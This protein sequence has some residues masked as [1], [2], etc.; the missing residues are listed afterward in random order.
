MQILDD[1]HPKQ[2]EYCG[3][4]TISV[5]L[6]NETFDF[7]EPFQAFLTLREK[8]GDEVYL[9]ESLSGP[10]RDCHVSMIGLGKLI[11]IHIKQNRIEFFGLKNLIVHVVENCMKSKTLVKIENILQ[12]T[13]AGLWNFLRS[14]E[15]QFAM[16]N[17]QNSAEFNFGFFAYF[18][19]DSAWFI[20]NLPHSIPARADVPDICLTIYSHVLQF[21]VKNQTARMI[22]ATSDF[23]QWPSPA[24]IKNHLQ[25]K[26]LISL[27]DQVVPAVKS[28]EDSVNKSQYLKMVAKALDY[29]K[30]GDIY[31]VQ[32]GHEISIQTAID[33]LLVYHRLRQR[34][35][36]PYL[37]FAPFHAITLIGASPELFV[38]NVQ[39]RVTLRPIAGTIK[40]Q[41]DPAAE[42]IAIAAFLKDKKEIA[43]H[44]M[45][46][47]LA[48][49]DIGRICRPNTLTTDEFMV[50]EKYSHV[51]HMVSNV[52]GEASS[53]IDNYQIIAATF[54]EGTVSGAPKIRALEI[55]EEIE[56]KRRGPYA[57]A[58]GVIDFS[59]FMNLALIIRTIVKTDQVYHIRASA[60]IVADSLPEKEWQETMMKMAA[61]YWALTDKELQL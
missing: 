34:N 42:A 2:S 59:G 56:T 55:I 20:E 53:G 4:H 61:T 51:C 52:F 57:G 12:L 41:Q 14:V 23:W 43:E 21:D 17:P 49:N 18:G 6:E 10:A 58:L 11:S 48:R 13:E 39:G 7:V 1:I 35:P 46:V 3:Q 16:Q 32:L 5:H 22:Y 31:Q 36:S 54:P 47:D 19:Y 30:T 45:L 33:P 29:I 8:F 25:Q 44:I 50:I 28:L 37:F 27:R 15:T 24:L 26:N 38:S 9:L 40:R 60:G